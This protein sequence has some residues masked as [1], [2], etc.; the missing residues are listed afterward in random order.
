MRNNLINKDLFN[1]K[2]AGYNISSYLEIEEK[3]LSNVIEELF[4]S[5]A[6]KIANNGLNKEKLSGRGN[7]RKLKI[8]PFGQ[9]ALK[10][11]LRGGIYANINPD[12]YFSI[13][14]NSSSEKFRAEEELKM[15]TFIKDLG[16]NVPSPILAIKT[17]KF[18]YKNWFVMEDIEEENSLV[19]LSINKKETFS[20][21]MKDLCKMVSI[22]IENRICHVDLHPG[23]VILSKRNKLYIIDFD[24]SYFYKGCKNKL[25]DY[26]L[27]RW[28]RAVIKHSLSTE[29]SEYFCMGLRKNFNRSFEI[30]Y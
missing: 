12:K 26:Y 5:N 25:R 27:C 7:V 6:E 11:Y 19:S 24:K 29:L 15:I 20:E 30:N 21:L 28:R 3:I 22:L 14:L 2:I 13:T 8:D 1:Y 17:N 9:I 18:F 10:Q 4:L 16:V 23:N